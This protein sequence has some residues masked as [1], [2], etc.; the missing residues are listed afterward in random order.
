MALGFPWVIANHDL[1]IAGRCAD[2]VVVVTGLFVSAS[3]A[4]AWQAQDRSRRAY[5]IVALDTEAGA[6]CAWEVDDSGREVDARGRRVEVVQIDPAADAPGY[7]PA[8]LDR[9]EQQQST[10][11]VSSEE[12][13]RMIAAAPVTC[14]VPRGSVHIFQDRESMYRYGWRFAPARC[15][16]RLVFVPVERTMRSILIERRPGGETR[17]RQI[18]DVMC[19]SASFDVWRYTLDGRQVIPG[20][21]PL[22][23]AGCGGRS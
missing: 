17:I 9:I 6:R 10:R 22:F 8:A 14:T 7:S 12:R 11:A 3:D 2:A 5:R 18:T 19:D 20:Q 1:R 16:G 21:P 4:R 15:R 13:E 23:A